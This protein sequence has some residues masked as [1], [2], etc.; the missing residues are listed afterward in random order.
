MHT[1]SHLNTGSSALPPGAVNVKN[2][3]SLPSEF[4]PTPITIIA[5]AGAFCHP[6]THT[7]TPTHP[8]FSRHFLI[9][10]KTSLSIYL[11][12]VHQGP[13]GSGCMAKTKL[14]Q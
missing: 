4:L 5:F 8:S 13:S 11:A 12:L 3:H 7:P 14:S 9:V 1:L 6:P 10:N 2:I